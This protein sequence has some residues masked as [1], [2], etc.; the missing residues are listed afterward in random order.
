MKH[1]A[2]RA[3][4]LTA[5]LSATAALAQGP[6]GGGFNPGGGG[7]N[8]GGGDQPGGGGSG[9]T[10]VYDDFI[11]ACTTNGNI[12]LRG[13]TAIGAASGATALTAPAGMTDILEG[14][15]AG[16]ATLARADFSAATALAEIPPCAFAG[17]I[18]LASVTLPDTCTAVGK[19]AF[20]G[21]TS[22][23]ALTAPGAASIGDDAFRGCTALTALPGAAA[24]IGNYAFAHTGLTAVDATGLALGEGAFAG[25]TSLA[26]LANAPDTF[27]D[28]LCS[29]CTA[30]DCPDLAGKTLGTAALAGI[31]TTAFT[32]DSATTFGDASLAAEE[33]TLGTRFDLADGALPA[34][35]DTTFLGRT[36]TFTPAGTEDAAP[37]Q[38]YD[39]VTWLQEQATAA[40]PLVEPPATYNTADLDTWLH[41]PGNAETYAYADQIEASGTIAALTLSDDASG[42]VLTAPDDGISLTVTPVGSYS[43]TD[44]EWL[45]SNLVQDPDTGIYHPSEESTLFFATLL[46]TWDW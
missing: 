15:F 1:N 43:L 24:D 5:A 30:L 37:L 35:A 29:G 11:T 22:L 42:F 8:P 36:V 41:T 19:G 23:A 46:C 32:V 14:A 44:G 2:F 16:H 17:C 39:L 25:C 27:P 20:S 34:H 10:L 31:P 4:L 40:A 9:G 13:G 7:F 18:D 28:A 38:A 26:T 45:P 6:G 3:F 21:C 33:A 12:I